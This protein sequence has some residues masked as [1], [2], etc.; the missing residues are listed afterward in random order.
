MTDYLGDGHYKHKKQTGGRGQYGEVY[1]R[2]DP[3]R[4]GE[5]EWF[6]DEIVGGTIPNNFK[7]AVQKGVVEGMLA[8]SVAGY[9][10]Q[11]VKVHMYDGSFHDVDSSEIAFKIA[12]LRAFRDAMSKARPVLLE[13]VMTVKV[14]IPEHFMGTINGDL[15]HRRGR[16]MGLEPEGTLQCI[17]AEVPLAE[18]FKYAAE[19]RSM[20]GGQGSFDMFFNRYDVVPANV[21]QKII[22]EAAKH[23]KADEEE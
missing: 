15:T 1:L 12:A 6:L 17:T 22:A 20:T 13:P 18:M 5:E 16:V 23:R 4:H 10:V 9:P 2:V 11:G 8:G 21:A 3:L 19:L 7:P 14:S